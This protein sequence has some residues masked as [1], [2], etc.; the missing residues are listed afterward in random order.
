MKK[1]L[2]ILLLITFF[3]A[4][5]ALAAAVYVMVVGIPG[6]LVRHQLNKVEHTGELRITVDNVRWYPWRRIDATGVRLSLPHGEVAAHFRSLEI[7]AGSARGADSDVPDLRCRVS[8][9]VLEFAQRGEK[10]AQSLHIDECH[11]DG[12]PGDRFRVA[13]NGRLWDGWQL[14]I[15]G[16]LIHPGQSA[17]STDTLGE[18]LAVLGS[19]VHETLQRL[20]DY[21]ERGLLPESLTAR[22][23]VELDAADMRRS[24]VWAFAD[25]GA[26]RIRDVTLDRWS[27]VVRWTDGTIGIDSLTADACAL[28]LSLEHARG[29]YSNGVLNVENF[30][31]VSTAPV[32]RLS[33]RGRRLPTGAYSIS[34]STDA[35][36]E[37]LAPLLPAGVAP[38]AASFGVRGASRTD[39][40]ISC[41]GPGTTNLVVR[42]LI[43]AAAV[44]RNEVAADLV[45]AAF[46]Y[47][48][49]ILRIDN[50]ALIRA[51]GQVTGTAEYRF[52][53]KRLVIDGR[54]TV[55][56]M[57][58]ARFIGPG[59]EHSL[60]RYRFEGPTTIAG[61]GTIG[62]AGN[63]ERHLQLH[64]EGKRIGW[65]WFLAEDAVFALQLLEKDTLIDGL[66]ARWCGGDVS[67][68]MRVESPART[69]VAGRCHMDLLVAG[70]NLSTVVDVFRKVEDRNAY[71]GTLSAHLALSGDVS[72]RF[73]DT[74]AGSGRIDIQDGYILSIPIFGGLS[75]YLSLLIPGLGYASQRDMECSFL[76]RDGRLETTDAQ[77]LGRLIT[78]QGKGW[79]GFNKDLSARVQVQ[80]L[81]DGLAAA[82]TRIVTSPL[83][84]ALEFELTGTTKEPRWRPV[85]TPDRLLKFFAEK[86]GSFVPAKAD[87]SEGNPDRPSPSP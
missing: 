77:L 53:E 64:V 26:V 79:Y 30:H 69:N 41:A 81:K 14:A 32:R 19:R 76:V 54:S 38:L 31:V 35:E 2:K 9:G 60:A 12:V 73:L 8:G 84:K 39:V 7:E 70:A 66:N 44:T 50:F 29:S 83:T 80:F 57:A 62:L 51:D 37:R 36:P 46:A 59:L 72:S 3:S 11:F 52:P 34:V 18:R 86:L 4:L 65:R 33:G 23:T 75:K 1:A 78:I 85:N 71:E 49:R 42:G 48:N 16:V 6:P 15:R 82:A 24:R 25:G 45:H 74:A 21:R 10:R 58:I 87:A 55:A 40:D 22:M 61:R 56:P 5:A 13:A 63:R 27:A 20:A 43:H 67:G 47:S 68:T 28:G 17:P